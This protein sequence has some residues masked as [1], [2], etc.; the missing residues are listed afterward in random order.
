MKRI[1]IIA[2]TLLAVPAA[3]EPFDG[4]YGRIFGGT[5]GIF[6]GDGSS[7]VAGAAVGVRQSETSPWRAELEVS[8]RGDDL[9]GTGVMVNVLRD[10]GSAGDVRVYGGL[11]IGAMRLEEGGAS[12]TNAAAQAILG[13]GVDIGQTT[14]LTLELR[15]VEAGSSPLPG[16]A[17]ASWTDIT[18]GIAFGF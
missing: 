12:A 16:G 13:A 6:D 2:M 11:G 8:R 5:S 7:P 1:A 17:D 18:A 15:H 9:E 3:A 4:A 10:V 14:E